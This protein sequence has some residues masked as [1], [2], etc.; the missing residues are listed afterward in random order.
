MNKYEKFA[1]DLAEATAVAANACRFMNDG[2]TCNLDECLVKLPRY[3]KS[4][5]EETAQLI[6]MH[7]FPSYCETGWFHISNPLPAQGYKN[8]KQAEI[9]AEELRRLGYETYVRY[10]ID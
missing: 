8:T 2:G 10:I 6:G 7:V 3:V 5:V 4:K 1:I 9:I